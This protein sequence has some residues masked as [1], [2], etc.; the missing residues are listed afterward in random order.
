[1]NKENELTVRCIDG[2]WR[3]VGYLTSYEYAEKH[4]VKEATV[5]KWIYYGKLSGI[6]IGNGWWIKE[7]MPVPPNISKMKY[8]EREAWMAENGNRLT[9]AWYKENRNGPNKNKDC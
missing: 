1:M 8:D 5:R 6:Q 9:N 2:V 4:H 7:D 3:V